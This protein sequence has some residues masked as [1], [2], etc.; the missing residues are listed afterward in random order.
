MQT[1]QQFTRMFGRALP[2]L[3][4]ECRKGVPSVMNAPVQSLVAGLHSSAAPHFPTPA[5]PEAEAKQVLEAF[6]AWN[7]ALATKD[8]AKVASLYSPD[9][10]LLP[11]VSDRVR[12]TPEKIRDY[13]SA[14]L[15]KEPQ[16]A[17]DQ[18]DGVSPNIRFLAPDVAINSGTYVFA[19][20]NDD[21]SRSKVRA[22]YS[23]VY[24]KR[25]GKYMIEEHHSSVLPETGG[26][27]V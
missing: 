15:K 18:I 2:S 27:V 10:V 22:R 20:K 4:R 7:D 26:R 24:R 23:Y 3:C 13:F 6:N 14:F 16:G 9:A 21:G 1:A 17:I 25:D 8:P 5:V 19:L 11:T 12:N